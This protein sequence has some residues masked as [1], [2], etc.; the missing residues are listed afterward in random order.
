MFGAR[1][2]RSNDYRPSIQTI[3][4]IIVIIAVVLENGMRT[5]TQCKNAA[6]EL[7]EAVWLRK[8]TS[9]AKWGERDKTGCSAR[10][11]LQF[12]PG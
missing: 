2:R 7:R 3:S 9:A 8:M 5:R 12:T 11:A 4:T 1:F 6:T 10:G